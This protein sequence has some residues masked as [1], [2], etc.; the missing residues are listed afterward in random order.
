VVLF[1]PDISSYQGYPDFGAVRAAGNDF[2]VIK[3]TE[4][5]ALPR[6]EKAAAGS[7][8]MVGRPAKSGKGMKTV[9]PTVTLD[10]KTRRLPV[11]YVNPTWSTNRQRAHDAGL[12][13]FFYHFARDTDPRVEAA[14]FLRSIGGLQPGE[15][16]VLDWEVPGDAAAWSL[17]FLNAVRD[18]AGILP[19]VY[20]NQSYVASF[21]WS[22]V[23][24]A[25]YGLWL[26]VYDGDPWTQPAA[27]YWGTAAMKQYTDAAPIPGIAGNCD[28]N[29]FYGDRDQLLAYSTPG[30]GDDVGHVDTISIDALKAIKEFV[31]RDPLPEDQGAAILRLMEMDATLG[32]VAGKLDKL[33]Q[34]VGSLP[35]GQPGTPDV[36]ALA[37]EIV[38]AL[39]DL[40]KSNPK[41]LRG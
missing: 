10:G 19:L 6:Q 22:S 3:V 9:R 30:G 32:A 21:D 28:R 5:M 31:W 7:K 24:G 41:L 20:L 8:T 12:V 11:R 4:G 16:L 37:Q 39:G 2:V 1:G 40:L 38:S 27:R 25:G 23:A 35:T 13:V 33:V 26:A 18:Q 15:G 17:A 29:A 34:L 14:Y 36:K